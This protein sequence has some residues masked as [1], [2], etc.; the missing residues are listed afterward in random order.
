MYSPFLWHT[1]T[2]NAS[3]LQLR[4]FNSCFIFFQTK[5]M[6]LL[7]ADF[8]FAVPHILPLIL[9]YLVFQIVSGFSYFF[10]CC[11]PGFLSLPLCQS[12][13]DLKNNSSLL[14]NVSVSFPFFLV[15]NFVFLSVSQTPN[16]STWFAWMTRLTLLWCLI[17]MFL[18]LHLLCNFKTISVKFHSS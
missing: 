14:K 9:S 7:I 8:S 15:G 10:W 2:K 13:L 5:F 6:L 1:L 4:N 16:K 17:V 11:S 3:G 12:K 18:D